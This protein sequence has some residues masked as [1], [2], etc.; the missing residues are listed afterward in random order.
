MEAD[1]IMKMVEYA[2]SHICFIIGVIVSDYYST[3]RAVINNTSTGPQGQVL[4][5][6]IGKLDE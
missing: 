2:S 1:A 4:K 5:S 3:I 6:S